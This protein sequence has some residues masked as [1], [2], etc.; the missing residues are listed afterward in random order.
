MLEGRPKSRVDDGWLSFGHTTTQS[1]L[2][3]SPPSAPLKPPALPSFPLSSP[4]L[5]TPASPASWLKSHTRLHCR[6]ATVMKALAVGSPVS[7]RAQ[8]HKCVAGTV[9]FETSHSVACVT[10]F[11]FILLFAI[12]VQLCTEAILVLWLRCLNTRLYSLLP[13]LTLARRGLKINFCFRSY[14]HSHDGAVSDPVPIYFQVPLAS[15][16]ACS[17]PSTACPCSA[18]GRRGRGRA[19]HPG[20][21]RCRW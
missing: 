4:S 14:C 3:L 17:R 7:A 13:C 21:R 20:R 6:M 16:R 12:Y 1:P 10:L 9:P 15:S 8:P 2:S 11:Q 5:W 19:A 18:G